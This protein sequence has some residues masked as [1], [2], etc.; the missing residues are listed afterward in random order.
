MSLEQLAY[1]AEIVG[2]VGVVV[3]LLYVA[4]QLRQNTEMLRVSAGG[5]WVALTERLVAEITTSREVAEYWV[6][7][8]PSAQYDSLDEV[9]QQRAMMFE[10]RAITN[11][12]HW[13]QLRKQGLMPDAQWNE[14]IWLI[15]NLGRRR[16]VR[17]AWKAFKGG[18]DHSFQDFVSGHFEEGDRARSSAA[19]HG[20]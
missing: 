17:E 1:L 15:Q 7:A 11:W 3:S 4:K 18:Y 14:L 2:V 10:W 6:K 19:S 12:N 9:D 5:T 8:G 20:A 13:F 16:A